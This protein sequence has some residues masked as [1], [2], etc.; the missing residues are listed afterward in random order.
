M[1]ILAHYMNN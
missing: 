1:C